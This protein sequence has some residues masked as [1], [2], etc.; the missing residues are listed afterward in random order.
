M[1]QA[2]WIHDVFKSRGFSNV[3]S[4]RQTKDSL[5]VVQGCTSGAWPTT[6]GMLP[7]MLGGYPI[8]VEVTWVMT[9]TVDIQLF[10]GLL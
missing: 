5:G 2:F 7:P 9:W 6:G 3:F 1:R 10:K 4:Y 8:D